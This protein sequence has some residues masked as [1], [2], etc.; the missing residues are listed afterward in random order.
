MA[1]ETNNEAYLPVMLSLAKLY[2]RSIWHTITGGDGGLKLW[3][4]ENE[5]SGRF[6]SW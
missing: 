6:L 4:F 5:E 2:V 3:G 1:L